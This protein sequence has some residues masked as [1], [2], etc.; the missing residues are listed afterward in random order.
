[1]RDGRFASGG[2]AL[3]GLQRFFEGRTL[4][5]HCAALQ[6]LFSRYLPKNLE[7]SRWC[8]TK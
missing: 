6:I 2:R 4:R 5:S 7:I 1:M 3:S 8:S